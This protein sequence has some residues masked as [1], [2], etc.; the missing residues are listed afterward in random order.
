MPTSV[1]DF[2][3]KYGGRLNKG[4]TEVNYDIKAATFVTDDV[5]GF[6]NK[7]SKDP[8]VR[9]AEVC[10][11][12]QIARYGPL[13]PAYYN[14]YQWYLNDT[15]TTDAWYYQTGNTNLKIAIVDTGVDYNHEDLSGRVISGWNFINNTNDAMDDNGHGTMCAGIAAAITNNNK[16]IAGISQSQI[17][18]V[19]AFDRNGSQLNP[20]IIANAITWAANNGAKIISMSFSSNSSVQSEQDACNYAFNNKG[21]L[22]VAASGN[23]GQLQ[24][25]IDFPAAYPNVL[26]IG[27]IDQNDQRC[28]F[29]NFGP[30]LFLVAPAVNITSTYP[31]NLYSFGGSGTS[32][33]APQVAGV[34]AL[35]WCENPL[36]SNQQVTNYL[37]NSAVPL[38]SGTPNQE[39]GY[40]KLQG[41]GATAYGQIWAPLSSSLPEGYAVTYYTYIEDYTYMHSVLAA[42]NPGQWILLEKWGSPPTLSSYD[43]ISYNSGGMQDIALKGSGLLYITIYA[44]SLGGS[45][46]LWTIC[47]NPAQKTYNYGSLSGP[48]SLSYDWVS[49]V[50]N[51]YAFSTTSDTNIYTLYT[52]WNVPPTS[53]MYDA[54]GTTSSPEQF[55]GPVTVNGTLYNMIYSVQG[56]GQYGRIGAIY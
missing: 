47:G 34:A 28:S 23:Y 4:G 40:G 46:K 13:D 9:Y 14:G 26:A 5:T 35:V 21:C 52:K 11:I 15:N 10:P 7:V 37:K 12:T 19:K 36:F 49:G 39:Y 17:L 41:F 3:V 32:F 30:Q 20:Q 18:A 24:N 29:S 56:S 54:A 45:Y 44:Y 43:G 6:I 31:N 55:A 38:G 16:G 25:F 53:V 42:N 8:Y 48:G 27:G 33:A 22:L 51:G 1:D 50:G 2:G